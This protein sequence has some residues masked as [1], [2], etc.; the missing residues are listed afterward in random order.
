MSGPKYQVSI[1]ALAENQ[2][3]AVLV[4]RSAPESI[5]FEAESLACL[6]GEVVAT[7]ITTEEESRMAYELSRALGIHLDV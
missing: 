5:A 6:M 7:L 1:F 3:R 4:C 2:W